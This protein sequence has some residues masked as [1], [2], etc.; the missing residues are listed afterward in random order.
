MEETLTA[1]RLWCR[2]G[3]DDRSHG[4]PTAAALRSGPAR[5]GHLLGGSRTGR[6]RFG[7]RVTRHPVAQTD[8][9]RGASG[10]LVDAHQVREPADEHRRVCAGSGFGR[11]FADRIEVVDP[12][13]GIRLGVDQNLALIAT[14]CRVVVYSLVPSETSS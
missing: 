10:V 11:P 14:F 7:H 5:L 8:D 9:H 1:L 6:H 13:A 12:S 3:L 2:G 4:M